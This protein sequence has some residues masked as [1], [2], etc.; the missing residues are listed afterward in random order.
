MRIKDF[1]FNNQAPKLFGCLF[2]T[3][4][5]GESNDLY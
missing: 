1:M 3:L 2:N 4:I 5:G